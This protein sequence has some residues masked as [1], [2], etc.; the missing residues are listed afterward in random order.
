MNNMCFPT[1]VSPSYAP[2]GKTLVSTTIVGDGG[3]L[4]DAE[5]EQEVRK[6]M[7]V[8]WGAE[9]VKQWDFLRSYNIPFSQP[10]QNVP[11]QEKKPVTVRDRRTTSPTSSTCN[12][13]HRTDRSP[14]LLFVPLHRNGIPSST[15]IRLP[16]PY[17]DRCRNF[18]LRRSSIHTD[19][20]RSHSLRSRSCRR[21]TELPQRLK[22]YPPPPNPNNKHQKRTEKITVI[23]GRT[24]RSLSRKTTNNIGNGQS[25]RHC[26]NHPST[27]FSN[28]T[29]VLV[30]PPKKLLLAD[31]YPKYNSTE[32]VK[33]QSRIYI[34][35]FTI[36]SPL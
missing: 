28:T 12:T 16:P 29:R 10:A 4:S 19:C 34:L 26:Q 11:F 2:P 6:Q 15:L 13:C 22:P 27:Q 20:Q 36:Y 9:Y 18:C 35:Y 30:Y 17:A 7:T 23:Q 31:I 24:T 33:P 8:W 21:C 5:M 14:P 25:L 1:T 3:R 32:R